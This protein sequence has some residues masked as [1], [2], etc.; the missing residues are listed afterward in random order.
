MEESDGTHV[1]EITYPPKDAPTI[2]GMVQYILMNKKIPSTIPN[3]LRLSSVDKEFP[4]HLIPEETLC[5]HCPNRMVL[6]DPICITQK[7]KILTTTGIVQDISTYYKYCPQ[8]G[9]LYRYQEW[10]E[11]LH[12]FNDHVLLDLP[13]CLTIRNLLQVHTAVSRIVEYLELTTG[14]QFP[15]ADTVFHGYLHFEALTNHEYQYSCVTCGDH[16]PVVIMDLHKKASFHLSVSDLAQP[17]EDFNGDVDSEQFWKALTEERIARGFVSSKKAKS[18]QF[19]VPPSFHFWAPWIGRKTRRSNCVLNTEFEKIRP[20][21]AAEVSEI[22]VSEDRL[23]DELCKQKVQVIRNLCRECGLDATGSRTDLLL[24]LS[25]EMKSR[26]A[27][28]KVFEKIWAASGGWAVIMCPCGIVYSLKC[29]IRA[30]SPRDFADMLLSWKHMP[31]IVIYDFARGLST[32]TNLRQPQTIPF[33][34]F[35]GRLMDPTAENIVKAKAGNVKV[36]LP[37]LTCKKKNPDTNGHPITGSAEHYVLYDRF[38]EDNT[39]DA[40]DSLRKLRLV[41]QLAGKVNSQVV[42]QLFAKLKKNNYFLNMALLSTHVFLM[43]NIIHHYNIRKN[44]ERLDH[45]KK[46]FQNI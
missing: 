27:Y 12:N 45:M 9:V 33:S 8:C 21:K 26:E 19:S 44:E 13:L 32:H 43:R 29:N 35:E 40:R 3:H 2:Q 10:S 16:P 15:S 17:P 30:E 31:N 28:D 25:Q 7:A 5:Y 4:R 41:P 22:T 1:G 42:E 20:A 37:W 46:E 39:K 34:P 18:L 11:G 38:H 24:R 6:S 36:S 14:V 23:R